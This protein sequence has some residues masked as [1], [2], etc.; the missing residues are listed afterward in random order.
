MPCPKH[1]P[2]I[3]LVGPLKTFATFGAVHK[4]A[5]LDYHQFPIFGQ[6]SSEELATLVPMLQALSGAAQAHQSVRNGNYTDGP[7]AQNS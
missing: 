3:A 5:P 7:D 6:F 4:V 2:A 1:C